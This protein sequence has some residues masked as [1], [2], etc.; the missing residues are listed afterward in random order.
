MRERSGLR[1]KLMNWWLGPNIKAL[2]DELFGAAEGMHATASEVSLSYFAYPEA[3]KQVDMKPGPAKAGKFY[4]AL[5]F[6]SKFPDGRVGSDP[7]QASIVSGAKL[8]D[9]AVAEAVADYT[10]FI[11]ST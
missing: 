9:I 4:D 7:S 5:D 11:K 10:S 2:A 1:C 3:V 6:R 8:F